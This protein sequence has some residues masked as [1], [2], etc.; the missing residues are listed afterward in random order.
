M[1]N[2][3]LEVT[4]DTSILARALPL[5]EKELKWWDDNR[6]VQAS[7]SFPSVVTLS[8]RSD[9]ILTSLFLLRCFVFVGQS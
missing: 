5:A 7:V 6:S 8:Q 4:N 1:I 2:R 3:Y 9:L